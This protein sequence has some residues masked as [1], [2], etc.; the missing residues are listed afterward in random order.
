MLKLSDLALRPDFQVGPMLVSPPRRLVEGPGGFV[1]VE[2]LIMQV[3]LLLLD[4]GGK[5]VTRNELFDQCWGGVYVGDDSLNRAIAKVRRIGA[6]VAPGLFEIETIPR[7]G[8]RLTGEVLDRLGVGSS[9][10]P[11][12][13]R[14]HFAL[15]RREMA[16]GVAG[17][18]GLAGIGTWATLN[19]IEQRRFDALMD[20]GAQAISDANKFAPESARRAFEEAVLLR[21]DSAAA[22]GWL[23]FTRSMLAAGAAPKDSSAAVE[24]AQDVANK[25]LAIDPKEPNAL[26]A[27]FELQGSTLDWWTRDRR[28]REIIGLDPVNV[29]AIAE[30]VLMLQ[31]AGLSRE[32]WNWNERAID[33]QPLSMDFLGKRA[34]KL[35]IAGRVSTADKVIDQLR[36]LY[37]T[38]P[39]PWWIRFC[40]YALT[41]RPQAAQAMAD[42]DPT[43]LGGPDGPLWRAG[44]RALD[45]RSTETIAKAR[46]SA[47][48]AARSSGDLAGQ[49]V[50][51][52][53][54]L[55]DIDAS[56]AIADGF[57]LSR[58]LIVRHGPPSSVPASDALYRV[59]TQWLFTP[60]CAVMRA[61][62]RFLPLCDGIGLTEYWRR[63]GVKPDFMRT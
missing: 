23:A 43:M 27:M 22:W 44:L 59:N 18:L 58:G 54:A 56:F 10:A 33:L 50:M 34:L 17:L 46:E 61:D 35:W 31:A 39:W 4:S 32:S 8:Y 53:A 63:R 29:N 40:I 20:Q 55:G 52:M 42:S 49:A 21:P 14:R 19:S 57:L 5:V 2:P 1:H 62:P 41:D 16:G 25:A 28:L 24:A 60:P 7:T 9:G 13:K 26:L 15:S 30:L 12:G 47:F 38:S 51:I 45:N 6:Q 11:S 48:T 37:P 3:F 36:A